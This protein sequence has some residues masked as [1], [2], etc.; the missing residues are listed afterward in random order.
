[1]AQ[2]QFGVNTV[3]TAMSGLEA[4]FLAPL[5]EAQMQLAQ[6]D[7]ALT[8]ATT[9]I[10]VAQ[11]KD[12]RFQEGELL[13]LKGECLLGIAVPDVAA[14]ESCMRQALTISQRQGAK[15]LEL[16]AATSLARL[17]RSQG[18][19]EQALPLLGAVCRWFSEGLDTPDCQDARQL[20]LAGQ[21]KALV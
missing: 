2:L 16:R 17:L 11:A 7:E 12:D 1:V 4:F 18:K 15:S 8:T 20:L 3:R 10:S 14:A 5:V 6:W 19:E 21:S 13:R 9:A